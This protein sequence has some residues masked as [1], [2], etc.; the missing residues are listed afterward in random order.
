[1]KRLQKYLAITL[2]ALLAAAF[3]VPAGASDPAAVITAGFTE[4]D[5]DA[6]TAL[7]ESVTVWAEPGKEEIGT[8]ADGELVH[9]SRE[10]YDANKNVTWCYITCGDIS[11]WVLLSVLDLDFPAE[12]YVRFEEMWEEEVEM[13]YAPSAVETGLY[14]MAVESEAAYN[15]SMAKEAYWEPTEMYPY[16]FPEFYLEGETYEEYEE[17]G[18]QLVESA[19]LSTFSA[20]VD[21]ASYANIRRMIMDGYG[22]LQIPEDA[23]RAEEFVNYFSYDF[24]KP[25]DG[26]MFS[27]SVEASVCPWNESHN[28]LMIGIR[29]KDENVKEIRQNLVFLV[30]ISGSMWSNDKLPLAK[31][32][33]LKLLDTLTPEDTISIVTY[34]SGED[35]VLDG[36]HPTERN[37]GHIKARI[38][39]LEADGSTAGEKGLQ[40]A[41]EVAKENYIEGGNNRIILMTDG[42]LNVGISD[43]D[44][45]ERFITEKAKTGIYL[46]ALGFGEGNLR[47]DVIERL[48]DCGNG[49]YSYIDSALEA[50]KVLIDEAASTLFTV[51]NDVKFQIEFNPEAVNAYRLIGYENRRLADT[52]FR[53]DTKDAGEIGAGFEMVALYELIPADSDAAINLRYGQTESEEN[54][55]SDELGVLSIRWKGTGSEEAEE[56]SIIINK[57]VYTD[58]PTNAFR[59]A[60]S[61]AEFAQTL[62]GS[63]NNGTGSLEHVYDILQELDLDDE[64]KEEFK[65]LVRTLLGRE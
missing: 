27:A 43:P 56:K 47:D 30:D 60:A 32:G 62:R 29:A 15:G 34:A 20:D 49:N 17:T 24:D 8:I 57:D 7:G 50:K 45:L 46:S 28:L 18:F 35:L 16:P 6:M 59:F 65:Y 44:D 12:G 64:Y 25:E 4:T 14:D 53:D 54:D 55:F 48:A 19:P 41:Y 38:N 21:T 23:V 5:Y 40:M 51:A 22:V 36:V 13:L 33:M 11:G 9:V 1:M 39:Q 52:D 31:K 26:E 2:T 58:N 3:V 61:V 10:W 63:D 37:L 42:D